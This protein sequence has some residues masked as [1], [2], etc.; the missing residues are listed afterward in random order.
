MRAPSRGSPCAAE[1]VFIPGDDM[2]QVGVNIGAMTVKLVALRGGRTQ[3]KV[4][5]HHG[6]PLKVLEDLIAGEFAD[7]ETFAV[8]GHLAH[9]SE[10]RGLPASHA[11]ELD[12]EPDAVA[13]LGG[14]SFL[15]YF[16]DRGI[17]SVLSHNNVPRAAASSSYS[18]S[19][20]WV[21]AGKWPSGF[22]LMEWLCH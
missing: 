8:S 16:L 5:L 18:R 13:S 14:E 7:G 15:V 2:L 4:E 9:L 12:A 1:L 17:A 11:R 22:P 20:G 19:D 21:S 6:K 10:A 3:A